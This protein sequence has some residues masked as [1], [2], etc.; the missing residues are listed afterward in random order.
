MIKKML[1]AVFLLSLFNIFYTKTS[2]AVTIGNENYIICPITTSGGGASETPS[3][4][5]KLFTVI[6]QPAIGDSIGTGYQLELGL[7]DECNTFVLLQAPYFKTFS[8][9]GDLN[10]FNI[11]WDA[12]YLLS[13]L[14]PNREVVVECFLNGI[15]Q[16]VPFPFTQNPGSGTC[17]V[18]NPDYDF[19]V[20]P[21]GATNDVLCEIYDPDSPFLLRRIP[22]TFLPIAF[23]VTVPPTITT[24]VN[25]PFTLTINIENK[26]LLTDN[27]TIGIVSDTPNLVNI[28][29]NVSSITNVKTYEIESTYAR[30]F[31]RATDPPAS[32]RVNV[33]SITS[34]QQQCISRIIPIT[35]QGGEHSLPEFDSIGIIQI[36]TI[37]MLV[38]A[39]VNLK[40]TY[41]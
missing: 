27:Y 29:R 20:S 1:F 24:T 26:G 23:G 4:N 14:D 18:P 40:K 35:I 21:N 31:L 41:L 15:Q 39:V 36:I 17:A 5:Y 10:Y 19:G 32:I 8:Y 34:C 37:A 7:Y 9:A 13:D 30:I 33:T 22:G 6:G 3:G 38:F 2:T 11:F 28:E 16:C 12:D 25:E